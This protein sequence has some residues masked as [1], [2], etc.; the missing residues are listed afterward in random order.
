MAG[1]EFDGLRA[2][3]KSKIM[4][5]S[6][7]LLTLLLLLLP[8]VLARG[9]SKDIHAAAVEASGETISVWV[10][11]G[12]GAADFNTNAMFYNFFG[13]NNSDAGA[14]GLRLDLF[15]WGYD[16]ATAGLVTNLFSIFGTKL[17][18]LAYPGQATND[19]VRDGDYIKFRVM[20]SEPVFAADSVLKLY[21]AT[22]AFA[23]TNAVT[24][25]N[26]VAGL[27]VTNN[28]VRAYPPPT[29]K[30]SRP[31]WNRE[32]N[33]TMRVG[34]TGAQVLAG[35]LGEGQPLACVKYVVRDEHSNW[36]TNVVSSMS[37][38][39]SMTKRGLPF[40]EYIWDVPLATFTNLD[41]LRI[42]WIACPRRGSNVFSTLLD[43]Y[44]GF[45]PQPTSITNLCDKLATYSTARAVVGTA[46]ANP[47]V[48]NALPQNINS[49]HYFG[50]IN[51]A[52]AAIKG[53]NNL[54]HGHNDVG[55]G[56]VY[57]KAGITNWTGG[58][59]D[60]SGTPKA[61]IRIINYP[62]ETPTL[63]YRGS[64]NQDISDRISIEGIKTAWIDF[65]VPFNNIEFL[66]FDDSPL[67][68]STS[69]API[70]N[71]P[72]VWIT[73]SEVGGFAQGLQASTPSQ[74]T[75][76]LLRDVRMTTFNSVHK[77]TFSAGVLHVGTATNYSL[78]FDQTGQ[79]APRG[80]EIL[81]N[82]AFYNNGRNGVLL[83]VF[84]TSTEVTTGFLIGN[85]IFERVSASGASLAAFASSGSG[86]Y[87][88]NG[89]IANCVFTGERVADVFSNGTETTNKWRV[90]HAIRDCI[91][92]LGGFKKDYEAGS[93]DADRFLGN[94]GIMHGTSCSGN[95]WV[96][97]RVNAAAGGFP[98]DW[99]GM[100][101]KHPGLATNIIDY[102]RWVNRKSY[103]GGGVAT[104]GNSDVRLLSTSPAHQL[105]NRR[106][107][108]FD[109][110]GNYK[111]NTIGPIESGDVRRAGFL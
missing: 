38:D 8:A 1:R 102:V 89:L 48:T 79:N 71:C 101:T 24:N 42:D 100:N 69:T 106:V 20:L 37:I 10:D 81:F 33:A 11:A 46:G 28:S 61:K 35:G 25:C 107:F 30:A 70:Q 52:S 96:E 68:E 2:V 63:T 14:S 53:T 92:D 18:R 65:Q 16:P 90:G 50:S 39:W 72:L 3:S 110:F 82:C 108:P 99:P 17:L 22:G 87:S 6:K 62:G 59:A 83:D 104:A 58:T 41:Q 15:S 86:T 103:D 31:G 66:Q 54:S 93:P 73:R 85:C 94:L 64:D 47:R 88:S 84:S 80:F 9:A 75:S 21:V 29:A 57:V 43:T 27:A 7:R 5:K 26:S 76:F 55:G 45:T 91:G 97:C 32:T 56:E 95:I 12:A 4:S 67:L 34:V 60:T 78:V 13:T 77:V 98:P 111:G 51:A 44:T 19:I 49:E 74:N 40:G 105:K 23:V 36:L 109:I